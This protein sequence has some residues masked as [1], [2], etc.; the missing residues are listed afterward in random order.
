VK[1]GYLQSSI[2]TKNNSNHFELADWIYIRINTDIDK[3]D[4]NWY[5]FL[6][7]PIILLHTDFILH[8]DWVSELYKCNEIIHGKKLNKKNY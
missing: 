6:I 2:K 8:T 7:D 1:N 3:Y 5:V 4:K